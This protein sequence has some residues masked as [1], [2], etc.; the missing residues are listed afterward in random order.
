MFDNS[1]GREKLL[2]SR[3]G[4][5]GLGCFALL[6]NEVMRASSS[7]GNAGG[8]VASISASDAPNRSS[9]P[10]IPRSHEEERKK[11]K[12]LEILC[13]FA[14]SL[15]LVHLGAVSTFVHNVPAS[16]PSQ[17]Q[18]LTFQLLLLCLSYETPATLRKG[19]QVH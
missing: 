1:I 16:L 2:T 4:F 9:N 10:D 8:G 13:H 5:L 11:E 19:E 18:H 7:T 6:H 17:L 15:L 12:N 3:L 14:I